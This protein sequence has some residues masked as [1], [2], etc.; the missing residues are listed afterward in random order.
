MTYALGGKVKK[1]SGSTYI[2]T[3]AGMDFMGDS[4]DGVESREKYF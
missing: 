1:V 3:P 4:A 2:I